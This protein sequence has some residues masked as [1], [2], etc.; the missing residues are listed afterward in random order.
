MLPEQWSGEAAIHLSYQRKKNPHMK[1]NTVC[2]TFYV[3]LE[4][5]DAGMT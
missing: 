1:T 2:E 5:S 3:K 4:L